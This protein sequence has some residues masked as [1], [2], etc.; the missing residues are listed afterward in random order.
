M[1]FYLEG[2]LM[3]SSTGMYSCIETLSQDPFN[4]GQVRHD[5]NGFQFDLD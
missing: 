3:T 1:S 5:H 4:G 2:I